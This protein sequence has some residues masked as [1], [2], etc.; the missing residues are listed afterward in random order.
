M[1]SSFDHS[2]IL[3]LM[4]VFAYLFLM[5]INRR[6]PGNSVPKDGE[7]DIERH[8]AGYKQE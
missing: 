1:E 6:P 5:V 3:L 4:V 8:L 7:A 2:M